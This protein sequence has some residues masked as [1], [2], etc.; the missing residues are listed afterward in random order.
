MLLD[1]KLVQKKANHLT[2]GLGR[3]N[4]SKTYPDVAGEQIRDIER[5]LIQL[6][7]LALA[8]YVC[9]LNGFELPNEGRGG[10]MNQRLKT[11]VQY[12]EHQNDHNCPQYSK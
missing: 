2:E 9:V 1:G 4:G 7:I 5:N 11:G 12:Y 8:V 3:N 10:N 6:A